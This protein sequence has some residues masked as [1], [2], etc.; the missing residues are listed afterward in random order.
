[1]K[2]LLITG[3]A[4]ASLTFAVSASLFANGTAIPTAVANE[5]SGV[6][7]SGNVTTLAGYQHD[8]KD[9]TGGNLGGIGDFGAG[10]ASVGNRDTF[11]MVVDQ[12]EL[13][14]QKS[15]GENIRLRGDVDFID[16][17]NT[18]SR[19]GNVMD[20][21]Q[22]YITA[23]LAAGNGIEFLFGKFNAPCGIDSVD[24]SDN[25]LIS[26]NNIYRYLTP[27]NLTG[28]KLY[29][30]FSDLVDWHFGVVND[31]NNKAFA[32]DSALPSIINTLGFHWGADSRNSA[33][34]NIDVG[35]E[36]I[37]QNAHFDFLGDADFIVAL[38]DTVKLA[39][40]GA[41]RQTDSTTGGANQKAIASFLA[42][43]Y[44]ASDVWDVTFRGD[45]EWEINP[46]N[47]RGSSGASTTG[48]NWNGSHEGQ[49]WSGSMGAGYAIADGAKMK[50][51]YRFDYAKT[52]GPALNSDYHS[53]LAE[54]AY[55]F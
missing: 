42:L 40:E 35:P 10:V 50:L 55:T 13:D 43:N 24:R 18:G 8:D 38:S 22:A 3:I 7:I 32:A 15:F 12:V 48:G 51:E 14:L 49:I 41:Y 29:Y 17:A 33:A 16:F 31:L 30:S 27:T 6:E 53:I 28:A 47:A 34:I 25:W 37:N 46:A 23:N 2:K 19:A 52:A 21:E 44:Q 9:A 36:N 26:Y 4:A 45:W 11:R 20:L 1:M 5:S 39:W 54:F